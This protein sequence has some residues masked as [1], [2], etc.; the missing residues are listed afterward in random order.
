MSRPLFL[1]LLVVFNSGCGFIP[2]N[3]TANRSA[4]CVEKSPDAKSDREADVSRAAELFYQKAGEDKAIPDVFVGL[5]ISG[6][7]SRAANFGLAT[8]Q[9]LQHFGLLDHLSVI[10]TTSGGGLPGAYYALK[11]PSINWVTARELMGTDFLKRWVIK[12]MM[13]HQ[14]IMTSLTHKDRSDV[15]AEVFDEVLFDN[16][17]YAD[18][19]AFSAGQRPIWLANATG[20]LT[21]DRVVFSKEFFAKIGADLPSYPISSAVM[22]SAAFPGVFN[23]VTL[24]TYRAQLD[25]GSP[26]SKSPTGYFHVFDGGPADN[27]GLEGLIYMAVS[28]SN[29]RAVQGLYRGPPEKGTRCL[30]L[31]VDAYPEAYDLDSMTEPDPRAWYDHLVD[32][33]FMSAFDALLAKRRR[34]LLRS[35]GLGGVDS[36]TEVDIPYTLGLGAQLSPLTSI[37]RIYRGEITR[38]AYYGG[39]L[40]VPSGHFRCG[41]WHINLSEITRIMAVREGT[42][43]NERA[44]MD[45]DVPLQRIALLQRLITQIKT[46]FRLTGPEGCTSDFLQSALFAA[47]RRLVAEDMDARSSACDLLVR[48]GAANEARC[49]SLPQKLVQE[50]D[51]WDGIAP[52]NNSRTGNKLSC[53]KPPTLTQD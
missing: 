19:G 37:R 53:T 21:G 30:L 11:G 39:E 41:V 29:A 22:A 13:P 16:A 34:E 25:G 12:N 50:S 51:D 2:V 43:A 18:L 9:Q 47:A 20:A 44:T 33:N 52:S 26:I 28:H 49:T 14:L 5:S 48:V 42:S 46:N 8:L 45:M 32:S 15:M 4:C 1:A 23:D 38:E 24:A 3:S 27:L 35:L 17:K 10:S 40:P 31:V 6:G 7:G 36:Y